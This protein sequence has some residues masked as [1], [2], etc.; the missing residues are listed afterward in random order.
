MNVLVDCTEPNTIC[1]VELIRKVVTYYVRIPLAGGN[2]IRE[3]VLELSNHE[4]PDTQN[5]TRRILNLFRNTE[6]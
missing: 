4:H 5:N 3:R 1:L 6:R 2:L